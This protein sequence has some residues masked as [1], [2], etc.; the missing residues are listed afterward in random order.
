M[1]VSFSTGEKLFQTRV[2]CYLIILYLRVFDNSDSSGSSDSH[3]N[4]HGNIL[5][6]P[7][8]PL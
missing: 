4:S 3:D 5:G 2:V 6:I 1:Y 8:G 7:S